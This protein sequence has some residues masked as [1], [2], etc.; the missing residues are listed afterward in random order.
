VVTRKRNRPGLALVS[1]LGEAGRARHHSWH[2]K[3]WS[4]ADLKAVIERITPEILA[5][6][7]DGAPEQ[8]SQR[9]GKC[10]I[11][12]IIMVNVIFIG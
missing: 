12:I 9:C 3:R 1:V 5:L 4:S 8:G 7:T 6:V 11:G 2:A 10:T